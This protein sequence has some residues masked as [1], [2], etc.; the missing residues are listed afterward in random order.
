M[1]NKMTAKYEIE[2]FKGSN[3]S[4][5]KM[6]IKAILRKD[7]C[8]AAIGDRP[9]E[10]IDNAKW[11]EMDANVIANIHLALADEVLSSVVKKKTAKEIWD[12]L[13]KLYES[14][15]LHNKIFLKRR[16]YTLRMVETTSVTDNINT[17]R[18]LFSQLTTLGQQ[19]E[20]M[21]SSMMLHPL[22]WKK[23][24]GAKRKETE[25]VQ[26]KQRHCWCQEE[27]QR[28]VALVGVK[29]RGGPNQEG[30]E[31]NTESSKPQ[32]CVA[33]TSEDGEILYSEAATISIYRKELTE[34]WLMDSGATWHMTP[35]RDWFHTYEPISEGLVFMGNDHALEIAGIGTIKLK[36]Y[37]GSI[38]TISGVRHVKDLKKNLLSVGQFDSLGCKIRTDNGI[39][40]IVKGALVV[41]KARK[42]VANLFMLMGETHHEK[43]LP[44]LTKVTLPFCEHYVTS[45]QHK[46]KF[47]TSTT[48]SKCILDLI[49]SNVWQAPVVS[50]GGARYFVSFIDDFSRRCWVYPIRRKADL[51]AVFKTFK[52]RVELESGKKIKCLRT[53]NGGEYTSDEF[54]NFCQHEVK[55]RLEIGPAKPGR[56]DGLTRNPGDPGQTRLRPDLSEFIIQGPIHL[57]T[58]TNPEQ[59]DLNLPVVAKD[60]SNGS[61]SIESQDAEFCKKKDSRE[62]RPGKP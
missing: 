53:D 61:N 2:R 12:T 10:I 24:I 56:P 19:I 25:T 23:K 7:N 1:V 59:Q 43:L 41:L 5:W 9:A 15:S 58:N 60:S 40:K 22:S 50:L 18:T 48:K 52:A 42:I 47:G 21:N 8:L 44:G 17:I 26:T 45:K 30:I 46:L 54:D 36:M 57:K 49:H 33:S 37:D 14:K 39:M 28:S 31:S 4:L 27:D 29:G 6:R 35:N 20:E 3:F 62:K 51:L 32:G 55:T 13:T 16:L 11:N 38:R 34:V